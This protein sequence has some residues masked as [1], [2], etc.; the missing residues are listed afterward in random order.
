VAIGSP[1]LTVPVHLSPPEAA[2]RQK[3]NNKLNGIKNVSRLR[4]ESFVNNRTLQ[5]G[6]LLGL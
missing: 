4:N 3:R 6:N 1:F 2:E 5:L